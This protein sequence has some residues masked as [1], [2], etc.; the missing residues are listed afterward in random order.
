[1][2]IVILKAGEIVQVGT[3]D[4]ILRNPANEFVEEFIGKERLIQTRPEIERV[5]QMMNRTPVT[6]SADKTL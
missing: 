6:V 2:R 1:D 5:E 3:P 4:E